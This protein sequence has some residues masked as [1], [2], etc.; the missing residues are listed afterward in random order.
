M[1]LFSYRYYSTVAIPFTKL[2]EN[3]LSNWVRKSMLTLC[4]DAC[5]SALDEEP[6]EYYIIG[7]KGSCYY[8]HYGAQGVNDQVS[9]K[10]KLF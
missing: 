3:I 5:L 4:L 9:F 1:F 6:G 10:N 7:F 2:V 8:Y